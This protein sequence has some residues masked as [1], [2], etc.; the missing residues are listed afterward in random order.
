MQKEK[1]LAALEEY[2]QRVFSPYFQLPTTWE[3]IQRDFGKGRFGWAHYES[4]TNSSVQQQ[5]LR[6][7][8][9]FAWIQTIALFVA[10]S[11]YPDWVD[12]SVLVTIWNDQKEI[13]KTQR[14]H[15]YQASPNDPIPSRRPKKR[16]IKLRM[17]RQVYLE[18]VDLSSGRTQVT[19]KTRTHS[20][21]F[22]S[23]R[24]RRFCL[25][26]TVVN[27]KCWSFACHQ[28]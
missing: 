18:E 2:S 24:P 26:G 7:N 17:T 3:L 28:F 27:A 11:K 1:N 4:F 20:Q 23:K 13:V 16:Q 12:S 19:F 21:N 15:G 22:R 14:I 25:F 10:K 8:F 5:P 9:P 6:L